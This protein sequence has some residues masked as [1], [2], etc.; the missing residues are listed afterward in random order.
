MGL[1]KDAELVLNNIIEAMQ[2]DRDEI[3]D[4]NEKFHSRLDLLLHY[5]NKQQHEYGSER[6]I[7]YAKGLVAKDNY[8]YQ[9]AE[10]NL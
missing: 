8:D 5:I 4:Y 2:A 3:F 10:S 7:S 6:M 9:R 1:V